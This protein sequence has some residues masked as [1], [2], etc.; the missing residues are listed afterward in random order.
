MLQVLRSDAPNKPETSSSVNTAIDTSQEVNAWCPQVF[1]FSQR[2]TLKN[3]KNNNNNKKHELR[4][5]KL[6]LQIKS[7][8]PFL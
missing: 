2:Q 5:S 6:T 3:N 8:K 7:L 4:K 1:R